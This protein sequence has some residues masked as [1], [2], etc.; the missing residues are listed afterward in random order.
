MKGIPETALD[1]HRA[2][3]GAA[4]ATVIETWGS[5]PRRIGAQLAISGAGEMEGSVSGG[6]V[7]G[8][9]VIEALDALEEGKPRV[10]EYGVSDGDAFAVGLA[11]G[12]TIRVLVEPVG[13]ALPEDMLADLVAARA[14][15]RP[16]AY[17]VDVKS[18]ARRLDATGHESRFRMDRS[19]FEADGT[20]FVAIHNPPLRLIVIGAVHIAQHLVP[21]ARDTGFDPVVIDPRE[22]FAA[23][24]RF[25][26]TRLLHDWPD[27][28][29][30]TLGLDARTA[31]CLLTHD[32]KLDDP[33]LIAALS[34]EVFYIG[35]L[36]STRTHG[37]RLERMAEAG[38]TPAHCA[39]IH[40]PIGLDI[41][42]AS[43]A[44]I[45]V[46]VLAEMIRVLRHGA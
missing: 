26:G 10:L 35:A 19:G 20:T 36:G 46:S 13:P 25:P 45:A 33:A 22:S 5:A 38:F 3:K 8:A 2:G 14:A 29:V 12:G 16:M 28:A 44:E 21:M 7:E 39:R 6:C 32:P 15:R 41:G 17:V 24:A 27:E 43:P 31:L 30:S 1:W 37:K 34:A 11:C 40:G 23:P 9:V 42:A 4:L 18:G